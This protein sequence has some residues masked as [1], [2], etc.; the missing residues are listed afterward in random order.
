MLHYLFDRLNKNYPFPQAQAHCDIPCGIYD[1]AMAQISALTV[2]R[3]VD[4]ITELEEKGDLSIA[5]KARLSR[6]TREKEEHAL[7]VKEEIRIIWGDFYK[8]PQFEKIPN[9][10]ELVHNIMMQGSKCKQNVDRDMAVELLNLVNQFAE[11]FWLTKGVKTYKATC[12]Y[13]PEEQVV[14]PQLG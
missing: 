6:L 5:D 13:P 2:I 1:P 9:A 7:K 10:H 12:P 8:Q 14:Y 11:G 3:M 4:L